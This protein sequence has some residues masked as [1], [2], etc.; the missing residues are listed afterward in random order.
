MAL[1]DK[2]TENSK[3][4]AAASPAVIASAGLQSVLVQPRI[5]EKASHM[6]SAGK[7]VFVVAN[8]AN[9]VEVKKAIEATYKVRVVQVNMISVKGKNRNFGRRVGK[10]SKFKKA[11]V[12]LK[13]GDKIEGITDAV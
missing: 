4:E 10:T 6:T 1:P 9:K 7:Y 2:K 12:T 11:I 13:K 3:T 5:S 8:K